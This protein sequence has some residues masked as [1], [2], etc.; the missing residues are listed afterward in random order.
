MNRALAAGNRALAA[1][2]ARDRR[3]GFGGP[4][5]PA[6]PVREKPVKFAPVYDTFPVEMI[7]RSSKVSIARRGAAAALFGFGAAAA[8]LGD[9]LLRPRSVQ[10]VADTG[11]YGEEA[12]VERVLGPGQELRVELKLA[13]GSSV[14]ARVPRGRAEELELGPGQIVP[15]RLAGATPPEPLARAA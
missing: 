4:G 5:V 11:D 12:L 3:A 15:V 6:R 14:W 13:D 7:F 8:G 9:L 2:R 10:L 1:G